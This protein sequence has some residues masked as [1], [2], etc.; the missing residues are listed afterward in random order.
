MQGFHSFRALYLL[1]QNF[2]KS[3]I[4][5]ETLTSQHF[6]LL[7]LIEVIAHYKELKHLLRVGPISRQ[8]RN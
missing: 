2:L 8:A 4:G 3:W 5:N 6:K 1:N 7:K